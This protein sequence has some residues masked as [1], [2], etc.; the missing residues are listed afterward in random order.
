MLVAALEDRAK[1]DGR[2]VPAALHTSLDRQPD[3]VARSRK[4]PTPKK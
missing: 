3:G 2:G 1:L 4:G